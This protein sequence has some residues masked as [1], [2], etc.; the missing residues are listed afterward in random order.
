MKSALRSQLGGK[1]LDGAPFNA[2]SQGGYRNMAKQIAGGAK[3][4]AQG[5]LRAQ[6]GQGVS[7]DYMKGFSGDALQSAAGAALQRM[8]GS[9]AASDAAGATGMGGGAAMQT[10]GA[11]PKD[12]AVPGQML[13]ASSQIADK[14]LTGTPRMAPGGLP[15]AVTS[16]RY[17]SLSDIDTTYA[18]GFG[19]LGNQNFPQ[20]AADGFSGI[21]D[22][23]KRLAAGEESQSSG[24]AEN[25]GLPALRPGQTGTG[26]AYDALGN[27]LTGT[28][29]RGFGVWPTTGEFVS[30]L[31]GGGSQTTESIVEQ[32]IR[33]LLMGGLRDTT[34][35][36]NLAREMLQAQQQQALVDQRARA[37][38]AGLVQTGAQAGIEADIRQKA[39]QQALAE[40]YGIQAGARGEQRADV[41]LAGQL[42]GMDKQ[43]AAEEARTAA[44]LEAFKQMYGEQPTD[45]PGGSNLPPS[46]KRVLNKLG[47]SDL[48]KFD[49]DSQPGTRGVPYN[50][51]DADIE[52]LAAAGIEL[53]ETTEK[54]TNTFGI[55][56]GREHVIYVD[57]NG[58]Y[59]IKWAD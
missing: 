10:K 39:A 38:R 51:T 33:D 29:D 14:P 32:T 26:T 18:K 7:G 6:E 17:A 55:V 54:A 52:E 31:R 36:E 19:S 59:Y 49:A 35:E 48:S 30:T 25:Y 11:V 53:T 46:Q 8:T 58:N 50:V 3:M 56:Y 24:P 45:E 42:Y 23:A 34:E 22:V 20:Q 41:G 1:G 21:D 16:D 9:P 4:G 15:G 37:G 5:M 40:I 2:A 44:I 12:Y 27:L 47:H 43:L 13:Y 57:Q 28:A